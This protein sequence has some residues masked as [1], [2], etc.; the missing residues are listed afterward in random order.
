MNHQRIFNL[1]E[2]SQ[3]NWS[4]EKVQLYP[5]IEPDTNRKLP[6]S[7][8][9]FNQKTGDWLGTVGSQYQPIQNSRLAEIFIGA[10]ETIGL[11]GN[12]RGGHLANGRKIY[13]QAELNDATVA[14][15][16]VQRF[17]TTLNSHDG[18]TSATFGTSN[19]VVIC[20]NTFFR[21]MK[22]MT[23]IRH[24]AKI[25]ERVEQEAENLIRVINQEQG[26]IEKYREMAN[27]PLMPKTV[28]ELMKGLF[29]VTGE[30]KLDTIST[31][32]QNQLQ[33]IGDAV[34]KEI[35]S[36]G[37]TVWGLFNGITY[38]YNHIANTKDR[39]RYLIEETG[40]KMQNKAFDILTA[41][42]V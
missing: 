32:K 36:H 7:F 21:A 33:D 42:L 16:T 41:G 25:S 30:T 23:K 27:I 37:N 15:D 12:T 13:L 20:Q 28:N 34:A 29:G 22:G 17:I 14:T 5:E 39:D 10:L 35:V 6:E 18:S 2:N 40:A 9:I 38:Y 1:L 3:L 4:V 19:T 31:R 24:T 26:I 8:G 11:E